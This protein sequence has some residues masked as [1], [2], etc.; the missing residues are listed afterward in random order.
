MVFRALGRVLAF[1]ALAALL[2]MPAQAYYHYIYYQGRTAPFSPIRAQ[3]NLAALP[4]NTLSFFVSDSGPDTYYQNDTFG[5][6]L[7]EIKQSLDVWNSVSGSNLRLAFGGLE[8]SS[9][10][11]ANT[12]GVD[13]VFDDLPGVLGMGTPNLPSSPQTMIGPTG[14]FVPITRSTVILTNNTAN[15]ENQPFPSYLEGYFT[16][17]VHEIGHA[18][19]LQ[20]TWTGSAM[21]QDVIRNTSRARPID[22]D[23][24][25]ALLVLYGS[26]NWNMNYGTIVG[27]VNS[28]NAGVSMASVVAISATGAAI[29]ALTNPDGSFQI[30]GVPAGSYQLYVHPLPPDAVP[31]NGL[32]L[33]L[34]QD[35]NGKSF[36]AGGAFAA[37][38]IPGTQNWQSASTLN[39]SPGLVTLASFNVQSKSSV[40]MYDMLTYSYL[41]PNNTLPYVTP[42]FVNVTSGSFLIET[43]PNY[44]GSTPTPTSIGLLGIG[45]ANRIQTPA[46]QQWFVY[47]NVPQSQQ[48]AGPRHLVYNVANDM[49]VL[50]DGVNFTT[51][52]PPSISFVTQNGDG[53]VTLNGSNFQSNSRVFFDGL[54][55]TPA[56]NNAFNNGALTVTPPTAAPG[57]VATLTVFNSDGQNSMFLQAANPQ[58]YVYPANIASASLSQN[59]NLNITPQSLPAG[60]SSL[61]QITASNAN[62]VAGQASVG[63]GSSD[64]V[65]GKVWVTSPTT[66]LA[67]VT[68]APNAATGNSE[69]SVVA[70]FQV[71][72]QQGAFQIQG[73]NPALPAIALP[74]VNASTGNAITPGSFASVFPANGGQFPNNLQ[75]T[76][77]GSPVGVQYS[78]STQINFF[79]PANTPVGTATLTATAN[80]N[81]VSVGVE[82]DTA[83]SGLQGQLKH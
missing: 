34:P 68:V 83:G 57:H 71:I 75:L 47:F 38:F 54:P 82:I 55:G 5:S 36:P 81:S 74:I 64:V 9:Q 7:G 16:T 21:S 72:A 41:G 77:N 61:V 17:V 43:E 30:Q 39:V 18:L 24:E 59:A 80:G 67:N 8:S 40:P 20:H 22:V 53:T 63:F 26:P 4:N 69:V 52:A 46:P 50:P 2:G 15:T 6:V 29:S 62:F 58:T 27:T 11:Q 66:L 35:F 48:T 49:Y 76:L 44:A 33:V 10:P 60:V 73:S 56:A 65:V 79:V 14:T 13:V 45:N 51:Q 32:G 23:D 37:Q 28:N 19:G 31:N 1:A 42:A 12:P 25:A 70:A 3:F 78:S